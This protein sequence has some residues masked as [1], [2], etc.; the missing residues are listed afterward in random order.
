MASDFK[1]GTQLGFAKAHHEITPEEKSGADPC[2]EAV[3]LQVAFKVIPGCMLSLL[4][5]HLPT[6]Q[7]K[8][9]TVLRPIPSYTAW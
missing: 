2:V 5:A 4:S 9:V 8:N 1:F 6:S 3:S 7:P